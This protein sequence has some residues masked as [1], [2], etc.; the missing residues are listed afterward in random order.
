MTTT[1][2]DHCSSAMQHITR[3][4][5]AWAIQHLRL[6]LQQTHDR[7]VWSKLMLAIRE[8]NRVAS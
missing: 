8:L 3:G 5:Y 4:Q 1:G 2:R 6:A 7:R